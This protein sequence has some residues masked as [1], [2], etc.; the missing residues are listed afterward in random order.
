MI[1]IVGGMGFIG[2]NVTLELLNSGEQLVVT[3]HNAR[4]VPK[5]IEKHIGEN[6]F[7]ES[8]DFTKIYEVMNIAH[9]YKV[10]SIISF[11]APPARGISP[12]EDYRIYTE[13]LQSLLET[14]KV[15]GLRRLSL[16][17]STSVYGS[18]S[19]GPFREDNPLP[20]QSRTQVEAF[21]KAMEI[22]AFHYASRANIN[23]VS[24]R[25][26]SI[27]GPHYYSMFNPMSR[28]CSA[29]L[30]GAEPDFTDRPNGTISEDDQG[31][32]T[33]VA[34]LARGI[35][36]VHQSTALKHSIYNIGSGYATSNKQIFE[37]IKRSIPTAICSSLI[38]GRSAGANPPNPVMDLSRIKE[39]VGYEP[40]Y[41]IDMGMGDYINHLRSLT[42]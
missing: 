38:P 8:M 13:G 27:Y 10:E 41:N 18:L 37:A 31:D 19:C 16:A 14:T 40:K 26:G 1:L 21:K 29:A 23:V 4:R 36:L 9:Q 15:L 17:S 6:V 32:W 42:N 30:K 20:I 12:Q 39:D 35:R 3:Q 22:H 25:I 28:I 2:Q 7:V 11:A 34:D 24:L 5:E 33:H